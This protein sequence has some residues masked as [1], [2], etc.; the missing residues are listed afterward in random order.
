MYRWNQAVSPKRRAEFN[1]GKRDDYMAYHAPVEDITEHKARMREQF[2]L[3]PAGDCWR[4]PKNW[5][6]SMGITSGEIDDDMGVSMLLFDHPRVWWDESHR[7]VLTLEPYCAHGE[8]LAEL[9]RMFNARGLQVDI[10]TESV[11]WPGH[12][13]LIMVLPHEQ[14]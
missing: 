3:T 8:E 14:T 13:I 12:T 4:P 11:Y 7:P 10:S 5:Q 2:N 9:V 6:R 1:T